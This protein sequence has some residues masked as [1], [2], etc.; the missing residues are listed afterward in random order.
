VSAVGIR[1]HNMKAPRSFIAAAVWAL[2]ACA[3][4]GCPG[5]LDAGVM[6]GGS[7]GSGGGGDSSAA[8][9]VPSGSTG[10]SGAIAPTFATVK[11]VF[12]GGGSI[13]GCASAP[14]HATGSM[15]PPTHP[16]SL[17]NDGRLYGT[18]T[19][20]LSAA[21]G[22]NKLVEPG[23]PAQ[24]ALIQILQ[25]PCGSTP[26]MPYLCTSDACIPD[27]YIAA[28]SQWIANCAPEQ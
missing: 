13:M 1:F 9:C 15:E 20:Y 16:L 25:G 7:S 2:F 12:A 27:D 14:C 22:N 17:Q 5:T 18:L 24:S 26:R 23:N 28:L 10:G 21:C 11:T 3:L 8:P 6:P 4:A 19:S